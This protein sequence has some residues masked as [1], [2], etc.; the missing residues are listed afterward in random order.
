MYYWIAVDSNHK[1][2]TKSGYKSFFDAEVAMY[3][4]IENC[5]VIIESCIVK[6]G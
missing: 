6:E 5:D 2:F 4:F 3:D 1:I